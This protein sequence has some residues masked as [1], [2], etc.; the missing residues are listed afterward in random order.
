MYDMNRAHSWDEFVA[1]LKNFG[2]PGQTFLFASVDGDIGLT[3][4]PEPALRVIAGGPGCEPANELD[5]ILGV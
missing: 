3:T 4:E 2:C 5:H 1:A